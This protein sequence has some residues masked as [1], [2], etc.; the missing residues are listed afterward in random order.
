MESRRQKQIAKLIQKEISDILIKEGRNIYGNA[1]VTVTNA[2]VTPDLMVARVYLSVLNAKEQETVLGQFE[3]HRNEIRYQLGKRVRHQ[4]R[5][6]PE[7][8]FFID[9]SLEHVFKMEQIFREIK[10]GEGDSGEEK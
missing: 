2:H 1:F 6:I 10:P 3:G 7:L 4:L 9:E 8:E 5:K